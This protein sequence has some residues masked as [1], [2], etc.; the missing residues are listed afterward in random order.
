VKLFISNT[1]ISNVIVIKPVLS[2][3]SIDIVMVVVLFNKSFYLNGFS[4]VFSVSGGP[5][6]KLD[7]FDL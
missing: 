3:T 4:A 7:S 1:N 5:G 6:E 2:V